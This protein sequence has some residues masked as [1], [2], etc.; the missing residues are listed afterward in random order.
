MTGETWAQIIGALAALLASGGWAARLGLRA[1]EQRKLLAEA[2]I[3]EATAGGMVTT[4][5]FSG[6]QITVT[7]LREE[8]VRLQASRDETVKRLAAAELRVDEAERR[9]TTAE[10]AAEELAKKLRRALR[11][12]EELKEK[13]AAQ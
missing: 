8:V 11:D 6:W 5:V 4:S 1:A 12:I 3:A 9:A 13:I 2:R 10:E 7:G